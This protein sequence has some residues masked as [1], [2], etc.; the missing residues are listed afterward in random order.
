MVISLA[1]IFPLGVKVG[2]ENQ[3]L[4]QQ[5]F[6]HSSKILLSALW[7]NLHKVKLV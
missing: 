1:Y 7:N 5:T 3:D 6:I 4:Q 2:L